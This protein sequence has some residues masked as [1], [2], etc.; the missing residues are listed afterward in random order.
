MYAQAAQLAGTAVTR[1]APKV[2]ELAKAGLAQATSGRVKDVAAVGQYVGKSPER[3]SIVA[4][5]LARAGVRVDDI[6]SVDAA[7]SDAKLA[8]IRSGLL[9]S[10]SNMQNRYDSASDDSLPQGVEGDI[11]RKKR[12]QTALRVYGSEEAYFLC[13]PNGGIPRGD[14]AWYA[15]VIKPR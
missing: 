13:H 14:F 1:Y 11:M 5:A 12:V 15:A 3:L 4:G 8:A 9:A 10:V 7:G 2:L 6:I